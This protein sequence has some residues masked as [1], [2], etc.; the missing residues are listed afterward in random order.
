MLE[1]AVLGKPILSGPSYY[2]F[3]DIASSLI[4][5]KAM[6]TV[7]SS[8]DLAEKLIE[9]FKMKNKGPSD[10]LEIFIT[11]NQGANNRTLEQIMRLHSKLN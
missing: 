7:D 3:A 11:Q 4:E 8:L 1:P 10:A 6:L 9:E 2:N 5:I